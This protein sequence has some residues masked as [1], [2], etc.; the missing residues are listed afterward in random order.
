MA[1]PWRGEGCLAHPPAPPSRGG[2]KN[3]ACGRNKEL[4]C[5]RL[6]NPVN[7]NLAPRQGEGS[8]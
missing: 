6:L 7:T 2:E 3:A 4:F 1:H 8:C 5:N